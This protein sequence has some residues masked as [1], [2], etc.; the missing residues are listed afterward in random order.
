MSRC[1]E[2][3]WHWAFLLCAALAPWICFAHLQ[4]EAL[5]MLVHYLHFVEVIVL[6][7]SRKLSE[8][9]SFALLESGLLISLH[10][11]FLFCVLL[12]PSLLQHWHSFLLATCWNFRQLTTRQKEIL[13]PCTDSLQT[14]GPITL[15]YNKSQQGV[16]CPAVILG[17]CASGGWEGSQGAAPLSCNEA[18]AY[19]GDSSS[20]SREAAFLVKGEGR[21]CQH[22]ASSDLVWASCFSSLSNLSST[23]LRITWNS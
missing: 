8:F 11:P 21:K 23:G 2:V 20:A 15:A 9:L 3:R 14:D 17:L 16:R 5:P 19:F 18:V 22:F 6:H 10:S 1:S 13:F 7:Q 12:V 4:W